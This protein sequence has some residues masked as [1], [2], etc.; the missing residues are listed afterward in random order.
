MDTTATLASMSYGSAALNTA[1]QLGENINSLSS[2]AYAE[3]RLQNIPTQLGTSAATG[4]WQFVPA[5]FTS[6]SN[7]Y[8]LGYTAA[9]ITNPQ[10]QAVEAAY[11]LRDTANSVSA[12]T[13]APAT[14]LQTYMGWV[15]GDTAASRIATS[16]GDTLL[17]SLT[18]PTF[19]RNNNLPLTTT[20]SQV[21]QLYAQRL[22][23]AANQPVLVP[24]H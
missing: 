22:G 20:V 18:S 16:P 21:N 7:Q 10:A 3:S 13:G 15:F 6:V 5:T 1:N 19:L 2:I 9:D 17:A 8:G 4:P 23:T 12:A 14:T 11:L 24:S